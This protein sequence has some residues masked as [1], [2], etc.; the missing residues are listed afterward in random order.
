MPEWHRFEKE[1]KSRSLQMAALIHPKWRLSWVH[2]HSQ[3]T[4]YAEALKHEA[5]ALRDKLKLAGSGSGTPSPDLN[6][7]AAARA[8]QHGSGAS[9]RS[10]DEDRETFR[11]ARGGDDDDDFAEY[12]PTIKRSRRDQWSD[13]KISSMIDKFLNAPKFVTEGKGPNSKKTVK[14]VNLDD[15]ALLPNELM[16]ALYVH[17]N[18]RMPSSA[19]AERLFS[20]AGRVFTPLRSRLKGNTLK[21]I[22]FI[23]NNREF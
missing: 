4:Q 7:L 9:S 12:Q 21:M 6:A 5:R 17:F 15:T 19:A 1:L 20:L 8:R 11:G 16:R 10:M 3:R 23:H 13:E 14:K 22:V 18:T 2:D